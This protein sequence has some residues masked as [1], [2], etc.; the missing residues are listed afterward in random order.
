MPPIT[1]TQLKHQRKNQTTIHTHKLSY[2]M[3]MAARSASIL[4]SRRLVGAASVTRTKGRIVA[5]PLT[6]ATRT[7]GKT[8][9]ITGRA[10]MMSL[11]YNVNLN[12]RICFWVLN[13]FVLHID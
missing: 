5:S 13:T 9:T 2:V 7:F 1:Q 6:A 12:Y 11:Y 8:Q 10:L 4:L 3:T